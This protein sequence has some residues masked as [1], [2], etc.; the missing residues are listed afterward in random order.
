RIAQDDESGLAGVEA[1]ANVG[2]LRFL[3]HG[4]EVVLA[5]EV[6]DLGITLACR[7]AHLEPVRLAYR[8]AG[9]HRRSTISRL[10][11][12]TSGREYPN[13][14]ANSSMMARSTS[15]LSGAEPSSFAI[16]V[17]VVPGRPQGTIASKR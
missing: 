9:R 11:V 6:L 17:T 3:A 12:S 8:G 4:V 16:D 1:L 5:Q 15:A 13:T 10:T 14:S 7:E 2:A